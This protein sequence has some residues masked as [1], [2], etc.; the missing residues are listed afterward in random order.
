MRSVMYASFLVLAIGAFGFGETAKIDGSWTLDYVSGLAIK[1][2]GSVEFDF[3]TVGDHLAGT[4]NVGVGWPGKAPVSIG[5]F[6]GEH[7][8]FTVFGKQWS[9]TGYPRMDFAG[10]IHGDGIKLTMTF[11]PN[12]KRVEGETIFEGRRTPKQ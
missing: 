4:A 8:S 1:T 11:Y 5:R 7:I 9:S 2:I 10:T 3:D 6:D 12:G